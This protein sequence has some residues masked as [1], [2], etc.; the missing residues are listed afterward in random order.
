MLK[1]RY[2]FTMEA[3]SLTPG[4]AAGIKARSDSGTPLPAVSEQ[5]PPG[6]AVYLGQ[7]APSTGMNLEAR[8]C[9]VSWGTMLLQTGDWAVVLL[10]IEGIW[11]HP[12]SIHSAMAQHPSG[13]LEFKCRDGQMDL[14]P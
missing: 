6:R 7:A 5:K 9:L 4:Q 10:G 3:S 12:L 14:L 2:A 1:T 11:G 13:K 8:R